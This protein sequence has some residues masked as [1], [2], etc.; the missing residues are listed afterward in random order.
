MRG[1]SYNMKRAMQILGNG[2]L[3][4]VQ[5]PMR[6]VIVSIALKSLDNHADFEVRILLPRHGSG[7]FRNSFCDYEADSRSRIAKDVD[8]KPKVLLWR[9]VSFRTPA[10]FREKS[11]AIFADD[12][13]IIFSTTLCELLPW[14]FRKNFTDGPS[15]RHASSDR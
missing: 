12:G 1:M 11:S 3:I 10:L 15:R 14:C 2:G 8:A 13:A 4:A 9:T 7:S 5:P 6:S